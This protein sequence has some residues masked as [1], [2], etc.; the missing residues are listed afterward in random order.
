MRHTFAVA[1]LGLLAPGAARA[2]A[3][4][5]PERRELT[6]RTR[7][8]FLRHCAECHTGSDE[9]G[10]SRLKL[11]DHKAVTGKKMP[12]PLAV[13]KQ[14]SLL[15][16]LV[17]DG[18]MPP[19]NRPGPTEDE[20]AVLERWINAGAPAY[21]EAF[22]ERYVLSTIT[23]DLGR[24][25]AA[26]AA[27]EPPPRYVSFAHLVARGDGRDLVA[28]V[29]AGEKRLREALSA[30]AAGE[31]EALLTPLDPAAT[32]FRFDAGKLGWL[33]NAPVVRIEKRRNAGAFRLT[34]FDLL[35]LEYP[36]SRKIEPNDPL[37]PLFASQ[38]AP[39]PYLR[40]DDLARA[41]S[42]DNAPT[43][44]AKDISALVALGTPDGA[45]SDGP[46]A[47]PFVKRDTITVPAADGRE[48]IP[49]LS[50]WYAGDVVPEKPPFNLKVELVV[51][52]QVA[53]K[54]KLD[55]AFFIRVSCDKK[56]HFTLLN[57][58]ADGEVRVQPV[59]GGTVILADEPRS[60]APAAEGFS[61]GSILGGGGSAV[62][63]FVLFASE[64]EMPVPALVRSNHLDK[65]VWRFVFEPAQ[66][67]DRGAVVR[68]VIPVTV[69]RK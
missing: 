32:V 26:K 51:G 5:Y 50:A 56:V 33:T 67:F 69:T 39:V 20:I 21:P 44:L 29:S 61:I 52:N 40:G 25:K 49:P 6:L 62:E 68:K 31:G 41:L 45:N 16:D 8:I 55:E 63:H 9:P 30:G 18:S 22:D 13:P 43:A 42:A 59:Q 23:A 24:V 11:L 1:V 36:S 47:R 2:A 57:V 35:L 66:K 54:V 58:L 60:L 12:I 34:P 37:A 4:D 14:R 10:Q 65:P 28:P 17:R 64:A 3:P 27:K 46:V 7:D 38:V 48:M 53:T 19:A 15:L